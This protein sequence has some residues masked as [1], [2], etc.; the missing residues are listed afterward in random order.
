MGA[1]VVPRWR[2]S[3]RTCGDRGFAERRRRRES[4]GNTGARAASQRRKK[5]EARSRALHVELALLRLWVCK[6]RSRRCVSLGGVAVDVADE[7][8]LQT[9]RRRASED[10]V[11][12]CVGAGVAKPAD[13]GMGAAEYECWGLMVSATPSWRRRQR[14]A[15]VDACVDDAGG[16]R[17]MVVAVRSR[18]G[19]CTHLR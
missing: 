14:S 18:R 4:Y 10:S 7:C 6:C 15:M 11:R 5:R 17:L 12:T 2:A 9:L 8:A 13:A 16:L 19:A 3:A 1:I